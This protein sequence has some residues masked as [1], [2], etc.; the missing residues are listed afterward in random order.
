M[1]IKD[2][3]E[4]DDRT[5]RKGSQIIISASGESFLTGFSELINRFTREK[6]SRGILL[7]TIWSANALTRR[8][9]MSKLPKGALRVIDTFSLSLGSKVSSNPDFIFLPTPA[10]L[11]SILVEIER[12]IRNKNNNSSFLVLDSLTF[13]NSYYTKGQLS[14][15][16]H[17]LLNRMLEEEITV[18]IFDQVLDQD[19]PTKRL[20]TS[21]MDRTIILSNG[22]EQE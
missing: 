4:I 18:V 16:F 9:G 22:G 13:I 7:S 20:L 21:I 3:S 6:G 15:F 8:I 5:L 17:Y 19:D 12:A 14:E 11:E 1:E 2:I 10:P